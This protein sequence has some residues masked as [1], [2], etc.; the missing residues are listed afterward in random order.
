MD[1]LVKAD[2][3]HIWQEEKAKVFVMNE[4]DAKDLRRPGKWKTEFTTTN[5]GILWYDN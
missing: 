2:A 3:K 1:K 4:S 5:G